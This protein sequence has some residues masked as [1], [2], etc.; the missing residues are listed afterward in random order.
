MY[1]Y[2]KGKIIEL[3]PAFL[4]IENDGIGYVASISLNTYTSL[5]GKEE[6][7]LYIHQVVKEDSNA[8]YGFVDKEERELFRMLISVSGVGASTGQLM[9]SSMDVAELKEAI[10][11]GNVLVLKGIKGIG[12]KTAQRIIIELKDKVFKTGKGTMEVLELSS[13]KEKEEALAALVMLG[14]KKAQVEK[15][16]QKEL[17]A[18]PALTVEELIKKSLKQL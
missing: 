6:A 10:G 18:N 14:F 15:V 9:L 11:S 1:E 17:K 8:L 7:L 5:S 13:E 3:T 12:V 4:I 16:L 2:I